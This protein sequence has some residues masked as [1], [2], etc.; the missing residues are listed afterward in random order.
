MIP[1]RRRHLR[2]RLDSLVPID[3]GRDN[4][5]IVLD[6]SEG[7]LRIRA[8]G[9]VDNTQ[10]ISL[11]FSLLGKNNRIETSA[12][13]AWIDGA[14]TG[15]GVRFI[16]LPESSHQQIQQW[17][18]NN[19]PAGS[20]A[21]EAVA[22]RP[23]ATEAESRESP[24]AQKETT[25]WAPSWAI[26]E[27]I[28][29]EQPRA[30]VASSY[31]DTHPFTFASSDTATPASDDT[32][33][34]QEEQE[35][36][37]EFRPVLSQPGETREP[38]LKDEPEPEEPTRDPKLR[39]KLI[40]RAAAACIIVLALIVGG[41]LYR[42]HQERVGDLFADVKRLITGDS[43]PSDTELPPPTTTS[44][45]K[46]KFR[47]RS[48]G[49]L[50]SQPAAEGGAF[51][52]PAAG[53]EGGASMAAKPS[54]PLQLQVQEMNNQR[55]FIELR[56]GPVIR[57][58]DWGNGA[59]V[60]VSG[61]PAERQEIPAYPLLALQKNLQGTVVL[62]AV[63]GKDGSVKNVQL[64]SGAP[65]LASAVLDAVR[66]WRYKPYVQNGQPVEVETQITV[67]F[68]ITTK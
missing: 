55:R 12:Q 21:P 26:T 33:K 3:L 67:D 46:R 24:P 5:G 47:L 65:I 49:Q 37:R 19:A 56:G 18:A 31:A 36:V 16:D 50:K 34:R 28:V 58:K 66:T 39:R 17:L 62:Q 54:R 44:S 22:T 63:I 4:G 32:F 45:S 60:Q 11:G 15:G 42:S 43:S 8:V 25:R 20:L 13:I 61:V 30:P 53:L 41:V 59:L 29:E 38:W 14:R 10:L 68:T 23:E 64:L 7:G 57:L 35:S 27:P 2:V 52:P 40:I 51:S 9:P 48:R 1:D 6:L